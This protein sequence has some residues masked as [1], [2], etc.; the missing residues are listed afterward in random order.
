MTAPLE[1]RVAMLLNFV[2]IEVVLFDQQIALFEQSLDSF[3]VRC[4]VH[5]EQLM[6]LQQS[7][8]RR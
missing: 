2:F 4:D 6:P 7:R 3:V 5:L 1:K 8:D